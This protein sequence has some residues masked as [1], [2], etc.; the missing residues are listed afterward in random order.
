MAIFAR[1]AEE[2]AARHAEEDAAAQA[3][4]KPVAPEVAHLDGLESAAAEIR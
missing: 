2:D 1:A 3:A 4:G